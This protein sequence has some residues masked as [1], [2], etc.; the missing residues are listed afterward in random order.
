MEYRQDSENLIVMSDPNFKLLGSVEKIRVFDT[1]SKRLFVSLKRCFLIAKNGSF[2]YGD[3]FITTSTAR[4]FK[5]L[6]S[7]YEWSVEYDYKTD[8]CGILM[9]NVK[10]LSCT[11]YLP[12]L[13]LVSQRLNS[14]SVYIVGCI[15]V[16]LVLNCFFI[17]FIKMNL[18]Y[19]RTLE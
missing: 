18:L 17:F 11:T 9:K 1:S 8:S 5:D 10:L 7:N 12:D 4:S 14:N 15:A 19:K 2:I 16:C 6:F 3:V 13:H